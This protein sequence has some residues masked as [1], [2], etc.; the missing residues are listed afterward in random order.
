MT[1]NSWNTSQLTTNGQTLIGNGSSSPSVATIT[2]G[3][4]CS[5]VNTAGGIQ[6]TYTGSGSG[7]W[8]LVTSSSASGSTSVDFTDLSSTYFIYMFVVDNFVPATD[9]NRLLYRTST[10][11]GS[12]YDSGSTD[13]SFRGWSM[14]SDSTLVALDGEFDTGNVLGAGNTDPGNA[15]N[16]TSSGVLYMYNPSATGHTR[17]TNICQIIDSSGAQG[18]LSIESGRRD[19]TAVDAIRFLCTGGNITSA[20]IRMYGMVA[21]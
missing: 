15:T 20:E 16:E 12:S 11:N 6:L 10:D 2:S 17:F 5:V 14:E 18:T 21:S 8:V 9:G 13:Y 4:N 19:T 1:Q 7:D 3:T